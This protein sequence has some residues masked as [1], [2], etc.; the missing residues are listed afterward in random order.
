MNQSEP[1]SDSQRT[2][3][4][5]DRTVVAIDVGG[6]RIKAARVDGTGRHVAAKV[7]TT[8]QGEKSVSQ[9][10]HIC[11]ELCDTTTATVALVVPG[12]LDEA[13]GHVHRSVNL[14]W[15]NVP[16]GTIIRTRTGLS[17]A[18]VHDVRAAC[19]AEFEVGLFRQTAELV[20]VAIGTGISAGIISNGKQLR[21]ATSSAGEIGHIIVRPGGELCACGQHGCVETYASASAISRRYAAASCGL[22]L[23]A[24]EISQSTL[25]EARAVWS[26]AVHALAQVL[27]ATSITLDPSII[28][29]AGGLSLAGNALLDPVRDHLDG[30]LS[31]RKAPRIELSGF[32]DRAGLIG[33]SLE[34]W[35]GAGYP[36]ISTTWLH[37]PTR[38]G[39]AI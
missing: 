29:L 23:S 22:Q 34:A 33:A 9:I 31:W 24:A 10:E 20:V 11:A 17:T 27:L 12:I 15:T 4:P 38:I 37:D 36:E 18:I 2:A 5:T 14:D 35:R 25:P 28:V 16:L 30:A 21:G 8:A 19:T 26:D 7:V 39:A 6:S 13:H 32:G 1:R 3:P